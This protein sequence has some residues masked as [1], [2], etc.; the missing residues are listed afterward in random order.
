VQQLPAFFML[1]H[2]KSAEGGFSNRFH[3]PVGS[4]GGSADLWRRARVA[5]PSVTVRSG[6]IQL[7]NSL[8]TLWYPSIGTLVTIRQGWWGQP[9]VNLKNFGASTGVRKDSTG[10]SSGTLFRRIVFASESAGI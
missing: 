2:Q 1:A 6:S 4:F 10:N 5:R 8:L 3:L 9:F 7:G